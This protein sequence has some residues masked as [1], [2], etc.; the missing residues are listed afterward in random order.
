M[1]YE[2]LVRALEQVLSIVASHTCTTVVESTMSELG[3]E[4]LKV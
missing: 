3:L 4:G 1:L 2:F